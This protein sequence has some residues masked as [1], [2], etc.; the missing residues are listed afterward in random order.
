MHVRHLLTACWKQ[1][2]VLLRRMYGGRKGFN[3]ACKYL[4]KDPL[5]ASWSRRPGL[6]S[7]GKNDFIERAI[8]RYERTGRVIDRMRIP[9]LGDL[10][11]VRVHSGWM[12]DL[13]KIL[14]ISRIPG[15]DILY[16]KGDTKPEDYHEQRER[17]MTSSCQ[18]KQE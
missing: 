2:H 18:A 15:S 13:R 4:F 12:R 16:Y 1:G 11:V 5:W 9:V 7:K 3:Y 8:D 14:G 6:G 17:L 10:L